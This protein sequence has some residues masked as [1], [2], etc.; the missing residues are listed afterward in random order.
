MDANRLHSVELGVDFLLS[1]IRNTG[2]SSAYY[3]QFFNPI[4][5]WSE[6]Y[7]ETTGYLIPTLFEAKKYI[8]NSDI[9]TT[10]YN[11]ADW[12]LSLQSDDGAL[13]GGLI[14]GKLEKS[15]FNTGQMIIGLADAYER[16][17]LDKYKNAVIKASKWLA[18]NQDKDGSWSKFHYNSTFFPSYYTRVAWPM[19]I[20]GKL[21]DDQDVINSAVKTLDLIQSKKKKNAFVEDAAF[22]KDK[23]AFLHTIAYTIRGFLEAGELL[24]RDDYFNT[25]YKW[26]IK[27]FRKY[28]LKKR[29]AGAYFDNYREVN[30]Y[31]CLTGEAQ[32]CI[33]WSKIFEKT[34]DLRLLNVTTK[35]LDELCDLQPKSNGPFLKRG[36]LK[37]SHPYWGRY[38]AFRQPNWATKFFVDAL[39]IEQSIYSKLNETDNNVRPQ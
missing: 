4:K 13:P 3:S 18:D 23:P 19:I 33:I 29:L 37:G 16:S 7:P 32:M 26:A 28:E 11:L 25:A 2:G 6:A 8:N 21:N 5:G 12:I 34:N 24:N 15:N 30:Y 10:A 38:I 31:R 22:T 36:G 9:E 1:S 39:T 20:G 17:K 14:G 27:L 35:V